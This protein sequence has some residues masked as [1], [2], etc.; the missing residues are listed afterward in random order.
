M[1]EHEQEVGRG[2][3]GLRMLGR[4]VKVRSTKQSVIKVLT[5]IENETQRGE[6]DTTGN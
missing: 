3:H 1:P 5:H 6:C 4:I 2:P